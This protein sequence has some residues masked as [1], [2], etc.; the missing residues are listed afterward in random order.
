MSILMPVCFMFILAPS[1]VTEFVVDVG[2][3]SLRVQW[4][5]P[6]TVNGILLGY[7]IIQ[8]QCK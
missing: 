6:N 2:V 3:T 4:D 5:S 7:Q 8:T 1:A